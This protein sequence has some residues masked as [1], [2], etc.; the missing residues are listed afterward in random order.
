MNQYQAGDLGVAFEVPDDGGIFDDQ[1]LDLSRRAVA[2][3]KPHDLRRMPVQEAP[4]S[5]VTVLR[6][7]DEVLAPGK[8]LTSESSARASPTV[9]T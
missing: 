8:L 1:C 5:K 7:D 3:A 6:R 9:R 4:L 2:H